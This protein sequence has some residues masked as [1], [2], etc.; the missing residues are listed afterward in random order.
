M[1]FNEIVK[2]QLN[3]AYKNQQEENINMSCTFNPR[4]SNLAY[5]NEIRV[6]LF[7]VLAV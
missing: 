6:N 3:H 7:E 1:A 2:L 5:V 4:L